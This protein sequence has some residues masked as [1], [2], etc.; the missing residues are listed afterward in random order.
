MRKGDHGMYRIW[1]KYYKDGEYLGSSV[2]AAFYVRKANAERI[3]KYR[4]DKE[5]DF[6]VEWIVSETNPWEKGA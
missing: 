2:S 1:T 6:Q 5:S 3:A 4:Y